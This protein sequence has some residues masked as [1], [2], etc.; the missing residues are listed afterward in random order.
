MQLAQPTA[1]ELNDYRTGMQSNA[2]AF[3]ERHQQEHLHDDSLFDRTVNHLVDV[4]G[5]YPC[6]WPTASSTWP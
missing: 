1:Q 5:T 4:C 6:S 2:A 3:I